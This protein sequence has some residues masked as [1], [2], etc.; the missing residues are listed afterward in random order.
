MIALNIA[1]GEKAG[2][3]GKKVVCNPLLRLRP[4]HLPVTL[5]LDPRADCH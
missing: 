1:P 3:R 4:R 2:C 5:V